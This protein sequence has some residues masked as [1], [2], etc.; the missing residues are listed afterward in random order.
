MQKLIKQIILDFH[1]ES[2]PKVIPRAIPIT[3][4]SPQ[5]RK[6]HVFIGMRRSGKTYLMYQHMQDLLNAGIEQT[7]LC[8][9]N[10]EDE[11]LIHFKVDN[12]QDILDSYFELYPNYAH[13]KDLYFFFDEI[14]NV[15]GWEKFIRRV[16]DKEYMQIYITGSSAKAL[17]KEIS[18]SLR[19]RSITTEVFPMS[20][21]E[22]L[23]YHNISDIN[24][25]SSKQLSHVRH[26][27]QEYL[28]MGGFPEALFI[29][30]DH[31]RALMQE[32][33]NAVV[34]RDVIER[35]MMTNPHIV[36]L[37]LTHCLQNIASGLS[38]TKMYNSFKSQGESL[39]K[40]SLY[41]YLDYFE[42][43]FLLFP[44][45][46][47]DLSLRKR[48]VNPK[49]IYCADPGLITAYSIKPEMSQS[50][51]L[52]NA[53]FNELRRKNNEIFYYKTRS[54]KEIDYVIK[55]IDGSIHLVQ[56]CLDLSNDSTRTREINA[57]IEAK[58]ELNASFT[59]IVTLNQEEQL[60]VNHTKIA[61]LPFWKMH[62]KFNE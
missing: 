55:N 1:S 51:S 27:A 60:S 15:D 38:I 48:Q 19:G 31:H 2:I 10:F 46:I 8:Y 57:L 29:G 9:I 53:V 4:F 18:T 36:K 35:H 58:N 17:S 3:E 26:L 44:I 32:Y 52:E 6:A 39:G 30:R 42:D 20:F 45:S 13:S 61:I 5:L 11:R 59:T 47:F 43:A 24:H 40:N 25:L 54:S 28:T 50:A 21:Q 16:L 12:F 62:M 34:Y 56:V 14:Q 7:K 37:F 49:K 41:E 23:H 33:V 22:F